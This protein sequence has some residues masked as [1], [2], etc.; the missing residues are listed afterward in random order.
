MRKGEGTASSRLRI[1]LT[2]HG[3]FKHGKTSPAGGGG[4]R[5][6]WDPGGARAPEGGRVRRPGDARGGVRQ[7]ARAGEGGGGEVRRAAV[8]RGPGRAAG[9]GGHRR[10]HARDTDRLTLRAGHEV[11]RGGEARPLQQ[12]DD[13]HGRRGGRPDRPRAGEGGAT[14]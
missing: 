1:T 11:R 10:R 6:H 5:E 8:V 7:R 4:G 2:H 14:G 3:G 12:D 9:G 13:H